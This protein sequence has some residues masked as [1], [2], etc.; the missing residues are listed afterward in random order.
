MQ[1][2]LHEYSLTFFLL[3][4]AFDTIPHVCPRLLC[5]CGLDPSFPS[6]LCP[7]ACVTPE[8]LTVWNMH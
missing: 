8:S 3:I 7:L 6:R 2:S 5:A 1:A 4:M